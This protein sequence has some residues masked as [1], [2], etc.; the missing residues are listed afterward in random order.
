MPLWLAVSSA[1]LIP[2]AD[3][4]VVF[5]VKCGLVLSGENLC[6]IT[7]HQRK[8]GRNDSHFKCISAAL[9]HNHILKQCVDF[10]L[11]SINQ[12]STR[13]NAKISSSDP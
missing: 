4:I 6:C 12:T 10:Q 9:G 5:L 7:F 3:V 1:F 11:C 13:Q 2:R 8:A